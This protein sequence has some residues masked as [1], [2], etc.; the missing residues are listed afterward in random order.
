MAEPKSKAEL[1]ATAL[2]ARLVEQDGSRDDAKRIWGALLAGPLMGVVEVMTVAYG[3]SQIRDFVVYGFMIVILL[4]LQ[5]IG[6]VDG[7]MPRLTR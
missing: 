2:A 4:L 5:F 3:G 1:R 7:G 6:V